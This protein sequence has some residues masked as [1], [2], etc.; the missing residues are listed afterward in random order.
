MN[1]PTSISLYE[2]L[3]NI[4]VGLALMFLCLPLDCNLNDQWWL[5]F[6]AYIAGAL[7]SKLNEASIGL[8]FRNLDKLISEA[9]HKEKTTKIKTYYEAYYEGWKSYCINNVSSLEALLAFLRNVWP[10]IIAALL[11]ILFKECFNG[12]SYFA[13][14]PIILLIASLIII[15]VLLRIPTNLDD[16]RN[17]IQG[18]IHTFSSN[19]VFLFIIIFLYLQFVYLLPQIFPCLK[20]IDTQDTSYK[21][22][23]ILNLIRFL[24]ILLFFL[25]QLGYYLQMKIYGLVFEYKKYNN[26]SN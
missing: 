24:L 1:M 2:L 20:C 19:P 26:K 14:K 9:E 18:I 21:Q 13:L 10:I 3:N 8:L 5:F 11:S 16:F 22:I 4:I 25:P 7:Y 23:C 15:A 6:V 17:S 12:N